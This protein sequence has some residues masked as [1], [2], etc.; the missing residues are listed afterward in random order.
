MSSIETQSGRQ[1]QAFLVSP[2]DQYPKYIRA[3]TAR[4]RS[5]GQ[6]LKERSHECARVKRLG[7]D[8]YNEKRLRK[9]FQLVSGDEQERDVT[10]TE[11][12]CNIISPMPVK[13]DI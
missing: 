1:P 2:F 12:V 5:F 3:G 8:E 9:V 7:H 4:V 11:D 10:Q 6:E 13:I